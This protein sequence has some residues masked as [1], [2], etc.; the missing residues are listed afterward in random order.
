MEKLMLYEQQKAQKNTKEYT[1]MLDKVKI[2]KLEKKILEQRL[3]KIP[4]LQA[5]IHSFEEKTLQGLE[6]LRKSMIQNF[7]CLEFNKDLL[8][9][10]QSFSLNTRNDDGERHQG[11][12]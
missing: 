5:K 10:M 8:D 7:V 6:M 4:E 12:Q 1:E 11:I 9:L 3:A 2:M